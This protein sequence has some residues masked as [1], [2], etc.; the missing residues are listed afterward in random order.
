M[1]GQQPGGHHNAGGQ[2]RDPGHPANGGQRVRGQRPGD[3][4]SR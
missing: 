1:D 3:Q 4:H 2:A